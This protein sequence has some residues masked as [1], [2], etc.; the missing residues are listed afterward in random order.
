MMGQN[1]DVGD[2]GLFRGGPA[3]PGTHSVV[4]QHRHGDALPGDHGGSLGLG[5]GPAAAGDGSAPLLQVG[6]GVHDAGD[7]VVVGVVAGGGAQVEAAGNQGVQIGGVGGGRRD[8]GAVG[9][10]TVGVGHLDL[11]QY[12]VAARQKRPGGGKKGVGIGLVDDDIAGGVEHS[13]VVHRGP[14][15]PGNELNEYSSL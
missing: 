8:V 5:E 1:I 13:A 2:T 10:S 9:L 7:A 3:L 15:L 12:E 14:P 4:G 11:S 6:D